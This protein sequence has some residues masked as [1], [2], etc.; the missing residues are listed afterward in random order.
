MGLIKR[1]AQL[2][3]GKPADLHS[4]MHEDL[5]SRLLVMAWMVEARDP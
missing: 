4:R 5:L 1:I 3:H 2:L